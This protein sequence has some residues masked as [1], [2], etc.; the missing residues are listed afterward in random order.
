M[1]LALVAVP[2]FAVLM[3]ACTQ[4][5]EK[6]APRPM[7]AKER[8]LNSFKLCESESFLALSAGRQYML[9]TR[10]DKAAVLSS[11]GPKRGPETEQIVQKMFDG[12][13]NGS[14]KHYATYAADVLTACTQREKI[15]TATSWER[16]RLCFAQTDIA[17]FIYVDRTT[18]A[19]EEQAAA[20]TARKLKN[21]RIYPR[22]LIDATAQRMYGPDRQ[23]SPDLFMKKT[24]WGCLFA[25]T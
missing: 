24:F 2:S 8:E 20:Q 23:T 22:P 4:P 13:D 1:R 12:V 16:K 5:P 19:T 14:I 21:E 10:R 7:T 18:G 15:P 11:M 17:F 3:A 6:P 9:L 25:P